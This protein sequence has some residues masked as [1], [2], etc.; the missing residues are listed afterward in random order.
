MMIR[1]GKPSTI[2]PDPAELNRTIDAARKRMDLFLD[3]IQILFFCLREYT[4]D[5][6]EIDA[7]TF[8]QVLQRLQARFQS[9]EKT[10]AIATHLERDKTKILDHIQRQKTYLAERETEFREIIDLMT[11]AMTG[12]DDGN[13][14]FYTSIRSQGER[15]DAITRLDDIKRI[16]NEMLREVDKLREM[17][18]QKENQDQKALEALSSQVEVLKQELSRARHSANTDA[19]T[20]VNNRKALDHYL[21]GLV[22]R[23]CVSRTPFSLL[24]M[25]LD[26]FK[27][28][29]DTYG[30]TVGDRMLLAFAEKCKS[31]I[32]KDDFLGRYGGEEFTLVLP[33]ASLRHATKKA[34]QLCQ[35]IA[36][37]RYAADDT[38][39][40]DVLSV[41]V[42]IGVGCYRKGDTVTSL[43]DR[44]DQC[45][46]EAK[47]NGKNRVVSE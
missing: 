32:R 34:K 2:D 31:V 19:L 8:K 9:E 21:A 40:T 38:P 39:S 13:R 29:N 30:H 35:T 16:K 6:T 11:A 3:S 5:I 23:N 12:L 26:D 25:D 7:E 20:G 41:T 45:L 10:R 24:M 43:I 33:G 46:Y 15:F 4:L 42:S 1:F 37:G 44:T 27:Q 17:V 47:T 22:D 36:A 28:L 14:D 18:R